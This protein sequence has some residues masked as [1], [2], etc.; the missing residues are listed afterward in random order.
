MA[1]FN[2]LVTS[3][4]R[5]LYTCKYVCCLIKKREIRRA[6][7]KTQQSIYTSHKTNANVANC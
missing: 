5:K 2:K 6:V 4:A 1:N 3:I 7:T